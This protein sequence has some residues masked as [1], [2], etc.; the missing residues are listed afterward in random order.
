M[1]GQLKATLDEVLNTPARREMAEQLVAI[2]RLA[3]ANGIRCE[4]LHELVEL[5]SGGAQRG[6]MTAR[7][8]ALIALSQMT[9]RCALQVCECGAQGPLREL[10]TQLARSQQCAA[11]RLQRQLLWEGQEA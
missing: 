1:S 8:Q 4:S 6:S 7:T 3:I 11:A 2:W 9:A 5:A 10:C